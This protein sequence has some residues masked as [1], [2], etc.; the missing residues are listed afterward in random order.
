MEELINSVV[1]PPLA[2]TPF[3][4]IFKLI[5][6]F[7]RAFLFIDKKCKSLINARFSEALYL[8][9]NFTYKSYSNP[10]KR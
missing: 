5:Q 2:G 7:L 1:V 4:I 3:R 6:Y 10:K 9:L 8:N